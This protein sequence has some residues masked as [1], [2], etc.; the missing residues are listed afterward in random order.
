MS[1]AANATQGILFHPTTASCRKHRTT[2]RPTRNAGEYAKV[3]LNSFIDSI[4]LFI[5]AYCVIPV[6]VVLLVVWLVKFLFGISIP[7]SNA[8]K[9]K[10]MIHSKNPLRKA[11]A[12]ED[13]KTES[14]Q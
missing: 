14:Q 1:Y 7:L 8:A 5:I 6:I 13:K 12:S 10:G 3:V 11:T 4:A 9:I 2:N